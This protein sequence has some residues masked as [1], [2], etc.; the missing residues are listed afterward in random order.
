MASAWY[1]LSEV[2]VLASQ[3][4]AAIRNGTADGVIV[5]CWDRAEADG[6]KALIP[7]ELKHKVQTT[8]K[9]F[10]PRGQRHG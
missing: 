3:A 5:K 1:E 6:V 9:E 8:W 10:G 2:W 4:I 7:D